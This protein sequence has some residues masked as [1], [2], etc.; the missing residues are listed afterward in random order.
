MSWL[1]FAFAWC[2]GHGRGMET[3][4]VNLDY[5]DRYI[6]SVRCI[7]RLAADFAR[8]PGPA[9]RLPMKVWRSRIFRI[10]PPAILIALMAC[11][12]PAGPPARFGSAAPQPSA[13]E[14]APGLAVTYWYQLFRNVDELAEWMKHREGRP[15]PAL[16]SLDHRMGQGKVLTS[17]AEDSD[18][19]GDRLSPKGSV[20]ATEPGWHALRVL[21]FER[22]NTATLQLF[23]TPPGRST[24][25]IV[26]AAALAHRR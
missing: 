17:D 25:E 14:L 5:L 13:E 16:A 2:N 24:P 22:R 18:V 10:V 3:H 20:T 26:P 12:A 15:G 8:R 7:F 1:N 11:A 9:R 6:P 23:W 4:M 21:Y 19:H